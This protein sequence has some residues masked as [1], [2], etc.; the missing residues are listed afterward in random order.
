MVDAAPALPDSWAIGAA[1]APEGAP[2]ETPAWIS[3]GAEVGWRLEDGAGVDW[4]LEDGAGVGV[5]WWLEDGI[6]VDWRLEDETEARGSLSP[7]TG[8]YHASESRLL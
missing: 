5:G 2:L 8:K 7:K 1:S 3:D 6:G 4:R